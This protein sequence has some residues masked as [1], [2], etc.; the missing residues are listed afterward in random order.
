[1]SKPQRVLLTGASGLIGGALVDHFRNQ[2]HE[3]NRLVRR[4]PQTPGEFE[5]DPYSGRMDDRALKGIDVA[6]NLSGA[7]IGSGRWTN[8]R[9]DVLYDSRI[10]TTRFLA[11][12]LAH[13][14]EAPRVFV[15]QSAIGIYGERGDE[16]LTERSSP[17]NSDDFL[18]SLTLDWEA[19]AK[20]A[21]DA[22]IRVVMPRTGLVLDRRAQLLK[23][24][25]PLFKSGVGGPLGSGDQWWSWITMAD[26]ISAIDYLIDSDLDGPVNLVGPNPVTQREF[27]KALGK[28]VGRPALVRAPA[29]GM[30]IALGA[31]KAEAIGLSSTR[32]VPE[33][34]RDSGFRFQDVDLEASLRRILA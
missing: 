22:G 29:T 34:L 7:G 13:A 1:M 12:S 6:I 21:I 32:V 17:G 33:A 5:W 28:V 25:L 23:R 8:E 15:S 18:V 16:I 30:R 27:A 26:N 31:E 3:V 10:T 24:L 20:P 11:E 9:K 19:A 2:G 14:D 4:E